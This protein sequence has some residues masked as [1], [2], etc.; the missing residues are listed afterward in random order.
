MRKIFVLDTRKEMI[1][2]LETLAV[3]KSLDGDIDLYC[4]S[5]IEDFEKLFNTSGTPDM[6]F[7][8][9]KA[10]TDYEN[11]IDCHG[12]NTAYYGRNKQELMDGAVCGV[13][14]IGIVKNCNDFYAKINKEPRMFESKQESAK[15]EKDPDV[16]K[17][18]TFPK[19]LNDLATETPKKEI[20][21]EEIKE[22]KKEPQKQ[23]RKVYK[24]MATLYEDDD[25]EIMEDD[26][27]LYSAPVEE[28]KEE[29]HTE[30]SKAESYENNNQSHLKKKVEN[31]KEEYEEEDYVKKELKKD[32]CIEKKR[33]KVISV[34]SAKGGV[35]KTTIATELATYLSL[36]DLGR[37]KVRAVIVDYNIDFGDVRSTLDAKTDKSLTYWATEIM[38]LINKGNDAASI[39]Y[40][41]KEIE[42]YLYIDNRSGLYVLPAP[43]TNVDS[44]NIDSIALEVILDNIVRNGEF[45][46]VICDTGNNTRDSTMIAMEKSDIILMIA[47]Q[48]VNTANCDDAFIKTMKAIDFDLSNVKLVINWILPEKATKISV[49]EIIEHYK[50]FNCVGKLNYN[51]DVTVA[52]NIGKPLALD[53]SNAFT[54]QMKTIVACVTQMSEFTEAIPQKKGFF[55]LFSRKKK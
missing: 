20:T 28:D 43:I 49:Q 16:P 47:T 45:D 22:E 8:S 11:N 32:L 48:N 12:I 19:N 1:E 27:Q 14:T 2:D 13:G 24:P 15:K 51:T 34:Y 6:I 18:E 17:E 55:G 25:L 10:I 5:N 40:S 3:I 53:P 39:E 38:E 30:I 41:R 50:D 4:A 26:T 21:E 35:G 33:T 9:S 31:V 46:Y 54:K 7:L 37:R 42:D 52:T 29:K 36:I 44:M 23:E